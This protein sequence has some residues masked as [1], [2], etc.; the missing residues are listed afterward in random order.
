MA[1]TSA[2]QSPMDSMRRYAVWTGLLMF[3]IAAAS[4]GS[5]AS[6]QEISGGEPPALVTDDTRMSDPKTGFSLI[7]DFERVIFVKPSVKITTIGKNNSF[8]CAPSSAPLPSINR[9]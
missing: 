8:N 1:T 3:F 4:C 6:G 5:G 9:R 2:D 7:D